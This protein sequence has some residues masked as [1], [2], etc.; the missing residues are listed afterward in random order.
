MTRRFPRVVFAALMLAA[1]CG[2]HSPTP[3]APVIPNPPSLSCPAD[4]AAISHVGSFPT[5]SFDIPVAQDGKLPVS[6]TCTPSPGSEFPIGTTSV[7]CE[8][9]DALARKGTCTFSV[10]VT[11][12]PTLAKTKFLAFGDS[13]TQGKTAETV[14]IKD[15]DS[16][17]VNL[18]F[19]YPNQLEQKLVARYQDQTITMIA[20]GIGDE[21]AGEGKNRLPGVLDQFKPDVLLLLEGINE[22]NHTNDPDKM[23]AA[24][25]SALDALRKMCVAGRSRGVKVYVATLTPVDPDKNHF[26][27]ATAVNT[28]NGMIKTM[29]AQESAILVDL[30]AVV[31]LALLDSS[32]LHLTKQGYVVVADEWLKAIIATL[33]VKTPGPSQSAQ[34]ARGIR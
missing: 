2:G 3:P 30:N 5:L 10:V 18:E 12:A 8:A 7:V 13:I 21:E 1:A 20:S 4:L 6:V 26:Y 19:G 28:L 29:A 15:A 22:L 16:K 17:V 9:V 27:Q 11:P 14:V 32:G 31:P 33:E 24:I 25:S 34:P 23:P